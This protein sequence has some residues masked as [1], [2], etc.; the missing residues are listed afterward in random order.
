MKYW[1]G[2]TDNKWFNFLAGA[3]PDEVNFWQPSAS[4]PFKN[5]LPGM[6][7]L[8]KLKSPY[9]HI[10]GGGYFVTYS[11]LPISVAWD[12]FGP[13]NGCDTLENLRNLIQPLASKSRNPGLIGCTVLAN[14]FFFERDEWI[15]QPVNWQNPTV[16]GK[17]YDTAE[18]VGQHIWNETSLRLDAMNAGLTTARWPAGKL[19]ETPEKYGKPTLVKPRL[20]Q[21]SFRVMVT[22]AY[23][24]RCAIT[25]ESTLVVLEAAHIVPYAGDG[26][27]EVSNGLLLRAD[28][29][30]LYDDGLVAVTPEMK[31]RVS[32]RIREAW[33]NGK[34]YYAL[35]GRD[36]TV[37]PAQ[38]ALRPDPDKLD[39]HFKNRFQA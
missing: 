10:G 16:V 15:A 11:Q 20:G 34:V 8:F 35:D 13:K 2:V 33:F 4:P 24:R 30:R 36:L 21:S 28:F 14:P 3:K 5:A 19:I 37:I 22:E 23:D 29:H 1:V 38:P 7:F 9:R 31:I 18:A 39:W 32:P 25:G 17:Y 12:I 26:S 27:H 6:P